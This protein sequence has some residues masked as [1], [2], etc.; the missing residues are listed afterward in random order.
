MRDYRCLILFSFLS[1]AFCWQAPLEDTVFFRRVFDIFNAAM[2]LSALLNFPT[3]SF[4]YHTHREWKKKSSMHWCIFVFLINTYYI[5][6]QLSLEY[7]FV[8]IRVIIKYLD[9]S[10]KIPLQPF[11]DCHGVCEKKRAKYIVRM[12]EWVDKCLLEGSNR[13]SKKKKEKREIIIPIYT[14]LCS[15]VVLYCTHLNFF[16]FFLSSFFLKHFVAP[17]KK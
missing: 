5:H 3:F 15:V 4:L 11:W 9:L 12:N 8:H 7:F 10:R 13:G 1:L 2:L 6:S 14:S 16:L 17:Y